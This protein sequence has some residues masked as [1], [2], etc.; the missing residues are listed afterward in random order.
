MTNHTFKLLN[1]FI[2]NNAG[3]GG[4]ADEPASGGVG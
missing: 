1:F 3:E 4:D 2:K